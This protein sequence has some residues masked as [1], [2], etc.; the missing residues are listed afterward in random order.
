MAKKK[1]ELKDN[2]IVLIGGITL[3]L[4]LMMVGAYFVGQSE[5]TDRAEASKEPS[6]S[7]RA[8]AGAEKEN[9]KA[10]TSSR[11]S[12]AEEK[13]KGEQKIWGSLER[14]DKKKVLTRT[15]KAVQE[16][17]ESETPEEGIRELLKRL[18]AMEGDKQKSMLYS[19]LAALYRALDPPMLDEAEKALDLAWESAGTIEEKAEAVYFQAAHDMSQGDYEGL[20]KGVSRID[21]QDLPPTSHSLELGVMMGVAYEQLG[22]IED[23][24]ASYISILE[25]AR[26][27]GLSEYRDVAN[28][29]RQAGM[30]LAM[31]MRQEGREQ[32]AQVLARRVKDDLAF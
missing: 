2:P 18:N 16:V 26:E 32:D 14:A 28:M 22:N 4:I 6:K 29:Y 9:A 1:V 10:L 3:A 15:E 27:I 17:M 13:G 23:A 24:K 25:V 11:K 8:K 12:T 19:T 20:L 30:N 21:G 31:I 7:F 5:T